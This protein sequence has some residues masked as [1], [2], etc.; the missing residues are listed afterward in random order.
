MISSAIRRVTLAVVLLLQGC[1]RESPY[2]PVA[3]IIEKHCVS[4]HSVKPTHA[5]FE[6]PPVGIA[7]DT[8]EQVKKAAVRIQAVTVTT[9][10]MPLGNET[11]ITDAER[12]A[13]GRWIAA[14]A[15]I[16]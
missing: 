6:A 4:C 2:A 9:R 15:A 5:G 16:E 3:P 13:L 10:T 7:F 14:G 1:V 12:E 11:G 8:P